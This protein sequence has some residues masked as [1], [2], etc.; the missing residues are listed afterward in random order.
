MSDLYLRCDWLIRP[1]VNYVR[2]V[3]IAQECGCHLALIEANAVTA[4][5]FVL[6]RFALHAPTQPAFD[7]FAARVAD[8]IGLNDWQ[9][10][11]A[12]EFATAQILDFRSLDT[13]FLTQ[14]MDAM[15]AYGLYNA[16]HQKEKS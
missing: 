3:G 1:G 10:M 16:Q 11:A 15:H 12:E 4:D 6:M 8:A 7:E 2:L 14:W 13:Q 9:P 5:K